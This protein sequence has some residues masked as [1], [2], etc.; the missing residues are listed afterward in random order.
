MDNVLDKDSGLLTQVGGWIG[1]MNFTEEERAEMNERMVLGVS[2]FV[3]MTLSE[4]TERSVTRRA[5]AVMWIK[6]QLAMIL[7][8]FLVA[9]FNRPLAEFYLS[10]TFGSLMV[11]GTLSI[12]AFFFGGHMLS[13]HLGMGSK[14]NSTKPTV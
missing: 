5:V 6:A 1:G 4:N 7:I 10:I 3:E 14:V 8:V 2:S 11:G 13:S 9:P 12:I